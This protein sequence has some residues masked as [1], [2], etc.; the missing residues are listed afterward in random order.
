[1]VSHGARRC[2]HSSVHRAENRGEDFGISVPRS[3][4]DGSDQAD[5]TGDQTWGEQPTQLEHQN[6][7]G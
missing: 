4:T 3:D 1:M 2:A 5:G 7:V 6:A